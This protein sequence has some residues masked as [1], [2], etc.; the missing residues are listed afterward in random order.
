MSAPAVW[1]VAQA[2]HHAGYQEHELRADEALIAALLPLARILDWRPS[3]L[4]V[5]P[6]DCVE[7]RS[8]LLSYAVGF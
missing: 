1:E 2:L 4:P 8:C 3:R 7:I 5:G 6:A